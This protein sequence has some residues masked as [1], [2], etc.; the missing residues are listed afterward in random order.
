[1]A[2][3]LLIDPSDTARRAMGGILA[4]CSHKCAYVSTAS[5]GWRFIRQNVK[6]DLVFTELQLHGTTDGIALIQQ[7]KSD[8]L[9]KLLPVVIYT[10]AGD[11]TSVKRSLDLRIQN[12]LIKPYHDDDVLAEI[13]KCAANP[14]RNRFFEEERSFC[15]MMGY[16][17]EQVHKML[18]EVRTAVESA[19][20]SVQRWA[21]LEAHQEIAKILAPLIEKAE[22]AGA[23]GMAESL[24]GLAECVRFGKWGALPAELESIAFAC[25]LIV[26][27]LDDTICPEGFRNESDQHS[28]PEKRE[29]A[30]WRNAMLSGN[31]P[32]ID[33]ANLQK[34]IDALPGC[35]VIS[36]SAASF[37]MVAN[38]HPSCINPLM[39]IVDR[40]PGLAAQ[41]LIAAN[42]AHPAG[43]NE[44]IIED[45]RLAVG[46]LGE[47]KLEA[48]ARRL[49][50][51]SE[52]HMD[53]PPH[54][55]WPQFWM[56]QTGV[57]RIAQFTSH[58]LE[59][60]S[61]E[62]QAHMAGLLHDI[63]K[64]VLLHLHPMGFQI[65]FEHAQKHRVPLE[66]AERLYLGCT[67]NEIGA[68]FGTRC[69]LSR[70]YTN[71]MNWIDN[72][73]EAKEDASLVAIVSLAR[74]LCRHNQVGASGDPPLDH[75]LPLEETAEWRVLSERLFPSFN[76]RKFE[77][78]VHACCQEIRAEFSGKPGQYSPDSALT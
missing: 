28:E 75:P 42:Q 60:Y 62:S 16:T 13:E 74:D 11:R 54:F 4:R 70:H 37:Q 44:N 32:V 24:T 27:Q 47:T 50:L 33:W 1:M 68:R 45:P 59:F 18:D 49:V 73:A 61:M 41:M 35:P 71:V 23:W 25:Q 7:L 2:R 38:G 21:V 56:F 65:I 29:R 58:Y 51:A 5:E 12:F 8:R 36:T 72:P 78:Q 64:L 53:L 67:T 52:R 10:A 34:Q 26:H 40:D 9:L 66:E 76:L 39:D 14:W 57:A 30:R 20:E 63:G 46:L 15:R 69:Q 19:V 22:T 6:V 31:C 77:L 17:A 55:N 43:E 48:Q 3:I